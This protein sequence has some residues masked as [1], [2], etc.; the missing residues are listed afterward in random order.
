MLMPPLTYIHASEAART[1]VGGR[2]V[3][4]GKPTEQRVQSD[5]GIGFAE[6]RR[7]KTEG[8]ITPPTHIL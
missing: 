7:R 1:T 6:S 2:G 3:G 5:A 8:Q 4:G